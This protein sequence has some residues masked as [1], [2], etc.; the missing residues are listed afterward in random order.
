MHEMRES[1]VCTPL[2]PV[3]SRGE[4]VRHLRVRLD[5]QNPGSGSTLFEHI[6][7]MPFAKAND[8]EQWRKGAAG[9][10]LVEPLSCFRSSCGPLGSSAEIGGHHRSIDRRSGIRAVH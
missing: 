8:D 6:E 3:A 2:A 5:R 9:T 7:Q 1:T 10:R 4:R